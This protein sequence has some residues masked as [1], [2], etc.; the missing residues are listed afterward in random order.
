MVRVMDI[1]NR[2]PA[3][4]TPNSQPRHFRTYTNATTLIRR[5]AT[6]CAFYF[7]PHLT[8]NT[9][10]HSIL[11]PKAFDPVQ[12][13]SC[14]TVQYLRDTSTQSAPQFAQPSRARLQSGSTHFCAANAIL[15]ISVGKLSLRDCLRYPTFRFSPLRSRCSVVY[16]SGFGGW[17]RSLH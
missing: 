13:Y 16:F 2:Y 15:R 10:N 3:T 9:D 5:L 8:L 1:T 12:S 14:A 7:F 4:P 6:F 11:L 17:R